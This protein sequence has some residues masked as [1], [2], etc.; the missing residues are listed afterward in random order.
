VTTIPFHPHYNPF[1]STFQHPNKMEYAKRVVVDAWD[2]LPVEVVSMIAVKVAES[3][4]PPLED[5]HSMRLCNKAMNRA[6][7]SCVVAHRFNLENHY[8]STVWGE[9][10]RLNA[11]L[12]TVDWLQGANNAKALFIKGMGDMHQASQWCSTSH[13]SRRGGRLIGVLRAGHHQVL[14]VRHHQGCI[15]PHSAC[16]WCIHF[17]CAG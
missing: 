16:V 10:H 7:S 2:H 1:P 9:R 14:Q 8:Q 11:Y 3:L 17:W 4:E 6:C 15:Q 13:T 12:Q 5:Y